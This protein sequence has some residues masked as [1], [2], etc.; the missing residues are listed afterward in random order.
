MRL[1]VGLSFHGYSHLEVG[2]RNGPFTVFFE[3]LSI[4]LGV[5]QGLFRLIVRRAIVSK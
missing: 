1:G 4:Q 2:S 3:F 5:K